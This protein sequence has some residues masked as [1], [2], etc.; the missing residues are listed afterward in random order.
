MTINEPI[1]TFSGEFRWLSNF[2]PA[3]VI[4]QGMTFPS[5]EHAYVASKSEDPVFWRIACGCPT[6][7]KVKR[8][9]RKVDIRQDFDHLKVSFMSNFIRQKFSK[10]SLLGEKLLSTGPCLIEEG[11]TWGDTF[12]G[13]C[14]GVG[15]NRL[16][17]IITEVREELKVQ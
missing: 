14:N 5:V 9:G 4:F 1:K 12:W 2:W 10:G 13:V 17:K 16:G 6:A 7:G 3:D 11:N 8:L 15:E